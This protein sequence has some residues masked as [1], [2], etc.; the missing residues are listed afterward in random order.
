MKIDMEEKNKIEQTKEFLQMLFV[1]KSNVTLF[2]K[3]KEKVIGWEIPE[4]WQLKEGISLDDIQIHIA[5]TL[6][7]ELIFS[8]CEKIYLFHNEPFKVIQWVKSFLKNYEVSFGKFILELIIQVVQDETRF[9]IRTGQ[10]QY[11]IIELQNLEINKISEPAITNPKDCWINF[12]T[13]KNSI[14][15]E[16]VLEAIL[17]V[18]GLLKSKKQIVKEFIEDNKDEVLKQIFLANTYLLNEATMNSTNS[19]DPY[20]ITYHSD[21]SIAFRDKKTYFPFN[22]YQLFY[23]LTQLREKLLNKDVCATDL[24]SFPEKIFE[25]TGLKQFSDLASWIYNIIEVWITDIEERIHNGKKKRLFDGFLN[26]CEKKVVN[27]KKGKSLIPISFEELFYNSSDAEPC[28]NIL[29]EIIPPVIDANN[30]YIGKNKGVFPLWINV[31]KYNKPKPLI[32][33]FKDIEYK[34]ALNTKIP[35]LN[36]SKDASEF[37]KQYSRLKENDVEADIKNLLSKLSQNG[38]LGN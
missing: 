30:N 28:L 18:K 9:Q 34:D 2:N 5:Y 6:L 4:G 13:N 23:F 11:I 19:V 7:N 8:T 10:L 36:L 37:R 1:N 17:A 26:A 16:P 38:K 20:L 15:F 35:G 22:C 33:H 12:F 25:Q 3:V 31:L 24:Q 27:A 14:Q 29:K 21:N 32:K